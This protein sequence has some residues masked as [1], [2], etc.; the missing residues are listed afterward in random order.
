MILL[1]FIL[2]AVTMLVLTA[3]HVCNRSPIAAL[4]ALIGFVLTVQMVYAELMWIMK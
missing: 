2:L 3:V 1:L 4:V